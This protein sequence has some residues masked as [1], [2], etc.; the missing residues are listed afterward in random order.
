MNTSA[1]K[2]IASYKYANLNVMDLCSCS[3]G[4]SKKVPKCVSTP[5]HFL[6]P[7]QTSVGHSFIKIPSTE[8]SE[9]NSVFNT[10][11]TDTIL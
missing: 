11:L 4:D 9:L 5:C 7:A 8:S 6:N 3:P 2:K 1:F 10:E